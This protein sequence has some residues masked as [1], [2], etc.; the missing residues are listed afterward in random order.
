MSYE[1]WDT[2]TSNRLAVF[3]TKAAAGRHVLAIVRMY[4]VR[5]LQGLSLARYDKLTKSTR[6]VAS[7][8]GLARWVEPPTHTIYG[9]PVAPAPEPA[10]R[11]R[12][13]APPRVLV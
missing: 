10:P 12:S 3:R 11:R 6:R 4:G 5:G 9:R 7:G 1:L 13:S 8:R 2:E